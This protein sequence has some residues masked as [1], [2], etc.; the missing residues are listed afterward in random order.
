MKHNDEVFFRNIIADEKSKELIRKW[1]AN[2][3][4]KYP[5][6]TQVL[7]A[8]GIMKSPFNIT[9]DTYTTT[10]LKIMCIAD[11]GEYYVFLYFWDTDS[12]PE[13]TIADCTGE[14]TKWY[15]YTI[16]EGELQAFNY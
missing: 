15:E 3:E 5:C 9:F 14:H 12:L 10:V 11:N 6:F 13:I 8:T 16:K 4:I 2:A 1:M 7:E